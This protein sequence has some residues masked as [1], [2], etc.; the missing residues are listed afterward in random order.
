MSEEKDLSPGVAFIDNEYIPVAEARLS[1]LDWGFT[2][3]DVTYDV[4]S[5]WRR[6]FFRLDDHIE[7]FQRSCEKLQLEPGFTDG[8][9][10][11]I[12]ISCVRKSGLDN[13]Y[14][15][16]LCTRGLPA[17]GSRDPRECTNRFIAFAIPYVWILDRETQD[18]GARLFISDI[19]R[20]S[21]LSV[22]PTVKNFHWADLTRGLFQAYEHGDDTVVLV[23]MDGN[24]SEGP[25]FNIFAVRDGGII[26]PGGT[27]LAGITRITVKELCDE[28]AIPYA[29]GTISP[30]ELRNADE[31][32][33]SSSA[34]GIMPIG[35]VDNI[36]VHSLEPGSI[37][38][39]LRERYWQRHDEGWHATPV[40]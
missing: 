13:A 4:V 20:I 22:D 31:I 34:G 10:R 21:P 1:V 5:V 6:N 23:D 14:V 26:T 18:R 29:Q 2:R 38:L 32:F 16:M 35:F 28:L 9:I 24:V 33:L 3:S 39:R 37:S 11:E 30:D 25:G 8:E 27:V 12:L 17:P 36:G 40:G 15:E 7:R 19:P